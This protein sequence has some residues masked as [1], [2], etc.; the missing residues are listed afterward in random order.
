MNNQLYISFE[1]PF[2]MVKTGTNENIMINIANINVPKEIINACIENQTIEVENS[3][4]N[5]LQLA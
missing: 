3:K 2:D 5:E 4:E 1:G